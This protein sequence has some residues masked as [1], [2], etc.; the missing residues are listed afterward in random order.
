MVVPP[1]TFKEAHLPA[2]FVHKDLRVQSIRQ[3]RDKHIKVTILI[4][5]RFMG[6]VNKIRGFPGIHSR[7]FLRG[8]LISNSMSTS[9]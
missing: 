9:T 5:L 6:K 2:P 8:L 1:A 4:I 3:K 7:I